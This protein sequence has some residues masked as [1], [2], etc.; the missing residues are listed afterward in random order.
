MI[1]PHPVPSPLT[2]LDNDPTGINDCQNRM[3]KK[4]FRVS[5]LFSI[6][7]YI[8]TCNHHHHHP[9]TLPP[10]SHSP[11]IPAHPWTT[12]SLSCQPPQPVTH[13]PMPWS[14]TPSTSDHSGGYIDRYFFPN[15]VSGLTPQNVILY[16]FIFISY[17]SF[18]L[19]Y[20]PQKLCITL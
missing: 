7:Q 14:D 2:T 12:T 11:A 9:Q 8:S 20:W 1:T 4:Q 3:T 5:F 17:F 18:D 13:H 6:C 10:P 15:L 16:Y 19:E